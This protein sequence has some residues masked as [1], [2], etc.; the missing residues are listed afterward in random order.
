MSSTD[1]SSADGSLAAARAG[2]KKAFIPIECNPTVMSSLAHNLGLSPALSFHDVF[3]ISDPELLAFVPR[4]ALALLLVF[5]ISEAVAKHRLEED[6]KRPDYKGKGD[7]EPVVWF[8]QTIKNACGLMG[9]LHAICNGEARE[10]I[11]PGSPLEG[12]LKEAIPLDPF[13]RINLLETSSTLESMHTSA[14]TQGDTAAPD[15]NDE[16]E[17]HYVCFVKGKDGHLYELDG[18]RNGPVDLG[19]L[20]DEDVLGDKAR[21]VVQGYIERGAGNVSFSLISLGAGFD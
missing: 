14:A 12:F 21:E 7:E 1:V 13:G 20:G 5:P 6:S 9:L 10:Q 15:A 4:P 16:V 19:E 2:S 18:A 3:S 17:L 8:K 11:V